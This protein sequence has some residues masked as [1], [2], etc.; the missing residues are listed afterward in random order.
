MATYAAETTAVIA[1]NATTT[2]ATKTT[3]TVTLDVWK[4][5]AVAM[6]ASRDETRF[7]LQGVYIDP[8]GVMVATNGHMAI[9]C[10]VDVTADK[11]FIIPL[12]LIDRIKPRKGVKFAV[13]ELD[14]NVIKLN[15][16]TE[17][18]YDQ[19]IDGSFPDYVKAL[20]RN[21]SGEQAYFIPSYLLV[22][23]KAIAMS[24]GKAWSAK[25]ISEALPHITPNGS[26]P[27]LVKG[28]TADMFGVLMPYK[29]PVEG[30][31]T[32]P[33]WFSAL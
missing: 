2:K 29:N 4:L 15:C 1:E 24:H 13:V 28:F 22:M 20:P 5:K 27:A 6:A 8:R 33:S 26:G 9:A 17:T 23:Q 25:K 12:G 18:Y 11:G 32:V 7:Y 19:E 14:G 16:N 31:E 3:V 10:K 21:F 30:G